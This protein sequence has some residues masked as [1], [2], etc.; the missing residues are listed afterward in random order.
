M[1]QEVIDIGVNA[2]DGTGDSLYEA[3][4]KINNN[5]TDLFAK[6]SVEAD[7][8]FFGNNITSRLSNADIFVHPSGTGNVLFPG[9]RFNDNNIE[10][11]N[12]ND[13]FK[14]EANGSGKVTIAGL[15]FSGTTI[16][17]TESSSVNINEDLIVDGDYTTADGFTFTGAQTF[18]S[19]MLFGN[20][21]LSDGSIVDGVSGE[22]S[23]NDENLTT[24]GTLAGA[25]GSQFGQIDLLNGTINDSSGAISFGNENLSTTGTL[26]VSGLTTMGS[27]SVSG[28][29]SFAD[30]I[31]VDNLTFNDNIISTSSNADLRL[32][33][34]GTGVV[35]VSNLTI[36][37]S[38]NFSDNVLKVT[39]SN[40][41]FDLGAS[42]TGSVVINNI[43]LDAG[44]IDNTVIGAS[45]PLAGTFTTLS[46][47]ASLSIDGVTISDNK[48]SA[49]ASNS[50]LELSGNG[51]GSVK[52][53]GLKFPTSDGSAN[54][55]LKTDGSGNLA[56]ATASATL[57]HSDINDNTTTV[58]SSATTVIDSFSSATYRS[59]KYYIS[60]SDATNSRFEIVEA[61]LIHGPSGDSTIEAYL[62]VFGSTTSYT[63][64]LC[65]F[66][67]DIDDG[68]VRLL[69]TNI[70]SDS[71][72][73]KFQRIT[74]DI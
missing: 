58:A 60:I 50:D 23:F 33:P 13:D 63:G 43:N 11:L 51:S 18:A 47:T 49:N 57:N 42:G 1:T 45:T 61:N 69:A 25:T 64:P 4:Q 39:T 21:Q 73:F 16:S 7:I 46:T 62:T 67:A 65:T 52:I 14:I 55:L 54:Q 74:F 10:V 27:I 48:V 2:D 70:S 41:D 8:K 30:S 31:T 37:S 15:G 5:F 29:T 32:T 28:V 59:G 6:A 35:N 53:S 22:I 38:L 3:G 34:G 68:N 20:L 17:A 24:T 19:G 44:T 66:T 72:V 12:S 9:I 56:F 40:A 26:D 36:D 71:T